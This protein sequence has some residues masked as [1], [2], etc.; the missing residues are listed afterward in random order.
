MKRLLSTS[1]L[2]SASHLLALVYLVFYRFQPHA[3]SAFSAGQPAVSWLDT[4]IWGV[5]VIGVILSWVSAA[6]TSQRQASTIRETQDE[7]RHMKTLM[8]QLV[9]KDDLARIK[10]SILEKHSPSSSWLLKCVQ[11]LSTTAIYSG[12]GPQMAFEDEAETLTGSSRSTWTREYPS[13]ILL[14][15]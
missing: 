8:A 4:L 9:T 13:I 10:Q 3:E 11:P 1:W 6:F 14:N 5:A 15:G 7:I 2:S 12:L